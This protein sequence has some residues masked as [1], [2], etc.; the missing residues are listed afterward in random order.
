MYF[1]L[2]LEFTTV[3]LKIISGLSDIP[4]GFNIICDGR[5]E[6]HPHS[7]LTITQEVLYRNSSIHLNPSIY[8]II[9][10]IN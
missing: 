2:L 3:T 5:V 1:L 4:L 9:S 10:V 8:L 7:Q 6:S